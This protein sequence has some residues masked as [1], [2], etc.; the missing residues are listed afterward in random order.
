VTDGTLSGR[1]VRPLTG[2]EIASYDLIPPELAS[3][4][5]II[6]VPVPGP[7]HGMALARFV[8]MGCDFSHDGTSTLLAHELVH[9]RQW[10]ELG[11]VGFGVRYLTQFMTG[12]YRTRSW[13][14]AYRQIEAECEARALAEE[15]RQRR[16][17]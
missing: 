17:A 2:E 15:W 9:V 5:R 12:L 3:R 14:K 7:Y 11:I 8:I 13:A 6:R 4:V 1:R 16:V 10:T